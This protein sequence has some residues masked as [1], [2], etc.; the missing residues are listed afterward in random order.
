MNTT[1]SYTHQIYELTGTYF[2]QFHHEIVLYGDLV[3]KLDGMFEGILEEYKNHNFQRKC[4][5]AGEIYD[6]KGISLTKLSAFGKQRK[7][8]YLVILTKEQEDGLQMEGEW[9]YHQEYQRVTEYDDI[10]QKIIYDGPFTDEVSYGGIFQIQLQKKDTFHR[11]VLNRLKGIH[12][13]VDQLPLHLQDCKHHIFNSF[14]NTKKRNAFYQL[15]YQY[16]EEQLEILQTLK[17]KVKLKKR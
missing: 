11:D 6:G 1:R 14:E 8:Y 17:S 4:Y 15:Y 9:S 2:D 7:T 13:F 3:M 10:Q 5:V 16:K 12:M